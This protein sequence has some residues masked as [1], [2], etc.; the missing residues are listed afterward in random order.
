MIILK[1]ILMKSS[2]LRVWT[3]LNSI[4][5]SVSVFSEHGNE[6]SNSI[7]DEFRD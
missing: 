5:D 4:Y 7:K 1:L 3:G 6:T 2:V